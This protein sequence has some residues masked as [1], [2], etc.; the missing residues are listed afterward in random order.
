[1]PLSA[2]TLIHFT[3]TKEKLMKIL[4]EDFR[5]YNC[6]EEIVL[7]VKKGGYVAPMV[8]FCD[9]PLSEVKSHISKYG[10][11]GLGM[12]KAWGT[13]RGLNPVLYIAKGSTL[14]KSYRTALTHF[15]DTGDRE[16]WSNEQKAVADVLRYIK[17]YEADL[18]RG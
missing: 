2:S 15:A 7:D 6:K 12:T 17:N 14:A 13:K 9:I 3:N 8:S 5:I 16:D 10:T 1:M 4:E 18:T 11:Y